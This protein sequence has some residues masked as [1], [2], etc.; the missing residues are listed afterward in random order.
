[1]SKPKKIK[2]GEI[3][4][5]RLPDGEESEQNGTRVCVCVS[6]DA[7]NNSSP[8]VFIFPITHRNKKEQ[9]CHYVLYKT[10]YPFFTYEKNTVL[11]EEG[12]SISKSRLDR[13][14]GIINADDI[15]GILACKEYIFIE[16]K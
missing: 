10:D 4:M 9:P 15:I 2:Q 13:K 16:K 14:I 8:N 12:R 11:C 7:R 5:C 3:W 1:M 6:V